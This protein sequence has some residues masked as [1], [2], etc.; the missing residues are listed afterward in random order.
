MGIKTEVAELSK[1]S[2]GKP[3]AVF[4]LGLPVLLVRR[5]AEVFALENRCAHM[6]CPLAAGKLDGYLLQCPCHDWRFDIRDGKFI[7]A[8]ELAVKTYHAEIQDGKIFLRIP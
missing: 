8:P 2:E 6:G 4:P 3:S 1:L 5:G 7:D